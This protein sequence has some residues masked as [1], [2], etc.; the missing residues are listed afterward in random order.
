MSW[1]TQLYETLGALKH[2]IPIDHAGISHEIT[3]IREDI[4]EAPML[5]VAGEFNAGKSTFIN[6]LL[7]D[8]VLTSDIIPA[9]A[10]VTKLTYGE[11][12]EVIGHFGDGSFKHF[13]RSWLEGLTAERAGDLESIRHDLSYIELKLPREHLKRLTIIDSPG[14][15]SG[16]ER[17]TSATTEFMKRADEIIWL[18]NYQNLGTNSE[19]SQLR[20]IR[21]IG[22][23]PYGVV[24]RIDL[25]N[26]EEESI[27]D[28][29]EGSM[30]RIGGL[31]R[32]LIGISAIEALE[33]KVEEDPVKFEWSNWEAI[34]PIISEVEHNKNQKTIRLFSRL[35]EV[36]KERKDQ[37]AREDEEL[38]KALGSKY[39]LNNFLEKKLSLLMKER[40]L[41]DANYEKAE[42][43]QT[44]FKALP[45][46][47][48][49]VEEFDSW[50]DGFMKIQEESDSISLWKNTVMPLFKSFD[51]EARFY[52]RSLE[53]SYS[54]Y[55]LLRKEWEEFKVPVLFSKRGLKSKLK[56]NE[57][58]E[59]LVNE[60]EE[61]RDKLNKIRAELEK[62][63]REM[64]SHLASEKET[65][66]KEYIPSL[67]KQGNDWNL[68][69]QKAINQ[70]NGLKDTTLD[71]MRNY[72]KNLDEYTKILSPMFSSQHNEL[73]NV[74]SYQKCVYVF[75]ENQ[76]ISQFH[77]APEAID[78]LQQFGHLGE[79]KNHL[80]KPDPNKGIKE[81]RL[82]SL[83]NPT[84][85]QIDLQPYENYITTKRSTAIV[86]TSI[87]LILAF[88]F[89]YKE[90][91]IIPEMSNSD[92]GTFVADASSYSDEEIEG[93][94]A[95]ADN[96]EDLSMEERW[97][98][99]QVS[100]FY[101]KMM[102]ELL[103]RLESDQTLSNDW[104]SEEGLSD[105]ST[106]Y[107]EINS[108]NL[109]TYEINDLKFL[110]DQVELQ[111]EESYFV[112]GVTNTYNVQYTI[113]PI[114]NT[115]EI[116]RVEFM[117]IEMQEP[118]FNV[119]EDELTQFIRDFRSDYQLALNQGNYSEV[120][121]YLLEEGMAAIELEDYINSI[122]GMGYQFEFVKDDVNAIETNRSEFISDSND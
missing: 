101:E 112:N 8:Q 43:L 4:H 108:G 7:G 86:V 61:E 38:S 109:E 31:V 27:E 60:L 10:V 89:T 75:R 54:D 110:T 2:W 1:K 66:Y 71:K 21:E 5:L 24:N 74:E 107:Q 97:S 57:S 6:A 50:M 111:A 69:Y 91:E 93:I 17:H 116:N 105:F 26:D 15:N 79:W 48:P 64:Y 46:K 52:N 106:Y 53:S 13:D 33:G 12:E 70:F 18:F 68:T 40:E 16:Y 82:A 14:L 45:K 32:G 98:R 94:E 19:L 42:Q 104:F 102:S 72:I 44:H 25:H 11:I 56:G 67:I 113:A 34:E 84:K 119:S 3:A 96:E 22:L 73:F 117:L 28:F 115:L 87:I 23:Y 81:I 49:S 59:S 51:L 47:S 63:F 58:Y 20:K 65:F 35:F 62:H 77:P 78:D 37:F 90:D 41:I 85:L 29:L 88:V 9:T 36:M 103:N 122:S 99:E 30:G 92:S 121:S 118:E 39:Y 80:I 83:K 100:E 114:E 120:A 95:I 55:E 76:M